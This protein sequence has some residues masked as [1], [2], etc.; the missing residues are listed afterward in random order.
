MATRYFKNKD[1]HSVCSTSS[2]NRS[3][4]IPTMP[5]NSFNWI[6]IKKNEFYRLK[7]KLL[8]AGVK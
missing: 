3:K 8:K 7:R 6:E 2:G 1:G 5:N 4:S